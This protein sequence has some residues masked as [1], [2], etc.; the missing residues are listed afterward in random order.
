MDFL[1]GLGHGAGM[2]RFKFFAAAAAFGFATWVATSTYSAEVVLPFVV[3]GIVF[4]FFQQ[5]I[6]SD[7]DRKTLD[8]VRWKIRHL[9]RDKD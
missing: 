2:Q 4:L 1:R 9:L 3:A 5:E 7:D 6:R 8:D